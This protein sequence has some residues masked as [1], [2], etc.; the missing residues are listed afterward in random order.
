[1]LVP[2]EEHEIKTQEITQQGSRLEADGALSL[3]SSGDVLVYGSHL[4]SGSDME[5]NAEGGVAVLSAF[6]R[7]WRTESHS[8]S[9]F[10]EISLANNLEGDNFKYT[11][12]AS[13][14][15]Q[16]NSTQTESHAQVISSLL[17]GGSSKSMPKRT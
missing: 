10:E 4:E 1:M 15:I 5:I 14:S 2:L 16:E 6:E 9:S 17:S 7:G 11:G 8:Q 3:N 13:F 12:S